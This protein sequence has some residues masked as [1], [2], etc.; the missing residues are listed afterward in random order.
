MNVNTKD[1]Q[2]AQEPYNIK[3]YQNDGNRKVCRRKGTAYDPKHCTS[4]VK[5]G[6]DSVMDGPVWLP[7]ELIHGFLLMM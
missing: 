7:G 4:P 3:L 1:L 2:Q 6:T 5:Q